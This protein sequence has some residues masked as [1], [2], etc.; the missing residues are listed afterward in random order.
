[1]RLIGGNI[2]DTPVKEIGDGSAFNVGGAA[3]APALIALGTWGSAAVVSGWVQ[4]KASVAIA[5]SASAGYSCCWTLVSATQWLSVYRLN[6]NNSMSYGILT[7]DAAGDV[8]TINGRAALGAFTTIGAPVVVKKVPGVDKVVIATGDTVGTIR[9]E[10]GAYT[11]SGSTLSIDG[12]LITQNTVDNVAS[13][14]RGFNMH[15]FG[16]DFGMIMF[17]SVG[18]T[19]SGYPFRY[20]TTQ[21]IGSIETS[22]GTV[23]S[24]VGSGVPIIPAGLTA[25][26]CYSLDAL[27][28][29]W[30]LSEANPPTL[31]STELESVTGGGQMTAN[32]VG[33]GTYNHQTIIEPPVRATDGNV[34][35]VNPDGIFQWA[36]E[37]SPMQ[38]N[39]GNMGTFTGFDVAAIPGIHNI[40][41]VTV[42][43]VGDWVR[44]VVV[45]C[46]PL[47]GTTGLF[48]TPLN[49]NP[50]T[51][52][53]VV[54]VTKATTNLTP[55]ATAPCNFGAAFH[56]DWTTKQI[57]VACEDTAG[58]P[59]IIKLPITVT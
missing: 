56:E 15:L 18:G 20:T 23:T 31:A 10:I 4:H 59:S 47:A 57:L 54:G 9:A 2:S 12:S 53:K 27:N 48:A 41:F 43:T 28:V 5:W 33:A 6:S 8:D 22:S 32:A 17:M 52:A 30:T 35:L 58:G 37:G 21:S 11:F 46:Y 39:M 13:D 16:A 7:L 19:L 51:G 45:G 55:H 1:M 24:L 25:N 40:D 36:G 42:D 29:K 26:V 38:A 34:C 49:V 14:L 3:A 44:G 50:L